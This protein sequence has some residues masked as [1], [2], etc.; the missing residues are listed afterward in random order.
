[1]ARAGLAVTESITIALDAMGGDQAPHMVVAG[2]NMARER[3][4]GAEFLLFGDRAPIEPLL[5]SFPALAKA[6]RIEHTEEMVAPDAKP[7][8]ALRRGRKTS[9]RPAIDAVRD[10]RA[11]AMV[12]A[13]LPP[14]EHK[15]A[16]GQSIY[17][18]QDED[19]ARLVVWLCTEDCSFSTGAAFDVSG[20]RATY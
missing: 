16:D 13:G 3:F 20:G 1:M 17:T 7:S 10:G 9:M 15:M 19:V 5:A 2:A 4:P 11:D 18:A 8:V 12:S 14:G 6:A